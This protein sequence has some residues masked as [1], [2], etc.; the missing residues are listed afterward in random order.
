MYTVID[1]KQVPACESAEDAH[2]LQ[3]QLAIDNPEGD[4]VVVGRATLQTDD[5]A[6]ERLYALAHQLLS[7]SKI[8][9]FGLTMEITNLVGD[10]MT[11][12][13]ARV[14]HDARSKLDQL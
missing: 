8:D 4:W 11:F 9:P 2:A 10:K 1:A 14:M 3:A 13:A 5:N 7:V 12:T 6:L